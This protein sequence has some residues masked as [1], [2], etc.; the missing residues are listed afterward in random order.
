MPQEP[1]NILTLAPYRFLPARTGG[2]IGIFA[3][4]EALGKICGDHVVGTVDNAP[5]EPTSFQ[6]HKLFVTGTKR[7]FPF[8]YVSEITDIARENNVQAIICEHPYM[9]PKAIAVAKKLG[10]PWYLRSHNIESERFRTLGKS[11]WK[12]MFRY[13]RFAMRQ[14]NGV[15]M[16][17]PEDVDWA[18]K[19]YKLPAEK[20]YYIPFGTDLNS[21]PQGR[22][23]ARRELAAT[24][25]LDP[26]K[27]WL[28]FLGALDYFP[29]EQAV[30]FI[31]DEIL[32]RL[33]KQGEDFQ[34][35]IGG[36]G[37]SQA[38][39]DRIKAKGD[40]IKYVGFIPV[41]DSFLKGMDIMLNPVQLGGG[42][43]TKAVEALGYNKFVVSSFSGAAGILAEVT[44]DNLIIVPDNDWDA[45][46][47]ATRKA[48]SQV[49]QIPQAFYETYYWGS[50]AGKVK[51][52]LFG[53]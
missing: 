2:H 24:F 3:M 29:N 20:C 49:P 28:Y 16:V 7:Y 5:T 36:K 39:Q 51:S 15:L 19:N 26:A 43:K 40:I 32:P 41:L 37:L 10:I 1:C 34:I 52:I 22:D 21:R 44:G 50:I 42:V 30:S 14:S 45:F 38:L 17:A 47:V 27:T 9:A 8:S 4:H 31:V 13:E 46:A 23:E 35:L 18:I 25:Q 6:L 11:W 33:E 12:I 53:H 48:F